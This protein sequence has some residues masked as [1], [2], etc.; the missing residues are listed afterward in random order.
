MDGLYYNLLKVKG[1]ESDI[2]I[3]LFINQEFSKPFDTETANFI[4]T[5]ASAGR[6]SKK[7]FLEIV[8]QWGMLP[9]GFDVDAELTLLDE[10]IPSISYIP[11]E[12]GDADAG[13][14]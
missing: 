2:L 13:N 5:A 12:G 10:E 11:S 7:T 8:K 14:Q 9:E 4:Q 1:I 3:D 6:I